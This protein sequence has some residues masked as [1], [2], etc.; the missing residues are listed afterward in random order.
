MRNKS[1]T[2]IELLVVIVIIGILAGVIMISTSSSIDKANIAKS[3]VFSESIKNNL[4][5][6]SVSEWRFDGSGVSDGGIAT[7]SYTQDTWGINHGII[8][9][10]EP[11]V[12]SGISCIHGS[13]LEFLSASDYI[14]ILD[15]DSITMLNQLSIEM[16]LRLSVI[17]EN[18][19]F[20]NKND[21]YTIGINSSGFLR[22]ET[23]ANGYSWQTTN[24][25]VESNKWM[26]IFLAWDGNLIKIYKDGLFIHS[27]SD[28]GT[29]SNSANNLFIGAYSSLG[30][31]KGLIDDVR[32]Y[33]AVLPSSRI[34]QNYVAGL[35]SLLSNGNISKEEYN[36]RIN[37]L[38]YE[39]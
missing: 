10:H 13:C 1:F 31:Y 22:A 33:S 35:D 36:E 37:A 21:E 27:F 12:K 38:A 23:G 15:N 32:L 6:N 30:L 24:D 20:I 16:W 8:S 26:Y 4:M 34:K 9:G 2:L 17:N 14:E 18:L 11:N 28:V 3:I 7:S 5:L 39:K 25:L 29:I 19:T